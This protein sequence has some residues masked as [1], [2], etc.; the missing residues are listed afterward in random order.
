[1]T[2]QTDAIA[3]SFSAGGFL[4]KVKVDTAPTAMLLDGIRD[5]HQ[6][7]SPFAESNRAFLKAII[8]ILQTDPQRVVYKSA[9]SAVETGLLVESLHKQLIEKMAILNSHNDEQV[10]DAAEIAQ[11]WGCLALRLR[12][13]TADLRELTLSDVA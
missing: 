2:D 10:I 12:E 3:T 13:Q 11:A 8:P 6:L 5:L 4:L 1:M 9:A 7:L